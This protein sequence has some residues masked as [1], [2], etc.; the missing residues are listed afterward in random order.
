MELKA[1]AGL[2]LLKQIPDLILWQPLKNSKAGQFSK[3]YQNLRVS[4]CSVRVGFLLRRARTRTLRV[5]Q[6]LPVANIWLDVQ[7]ESALSPCLRALRESRFAAKAGIANASNR[8]LYI[9]FEAEGAGFEPARPEACRFSRPVVSSTHPPLR[10]AFELYAL[11]PITKPLLAYA[12]WCRPRADDH[13]RTE[14]PV[15]LA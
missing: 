6:S 10:Y 5:R 12:R 8:M 1:I 13:H 11:S 14:R 7:R 4:V 9:Q 3:G 2:Q 15:G